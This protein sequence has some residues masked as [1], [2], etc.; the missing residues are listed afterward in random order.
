MALKQNAADQA[1]DRIRKGILGGEFPAG[2]TLPGER[3]LSERLGVSRLTLRSALANLQAQGLIEK[4]HGSGNLV[5]DYRERGGVELIAHLARHAIEGGKVPLSLLGDLLE[6]RRL[7]ATELLGLVAARATSEELRGLRTHRATMG[8]LLGDADAFM[9]ADLQF[10]RLLVRAAH[11]LTLELL[12]NTVQ[13]MVM[14]HPGLEAAFGVNAP[15]TLKTYDRVLEL[16]ES[17]DPDQVRAFARS[18]FEPLDRRTMDRL[19]EVARALEGAG[20]LKKT[21]G[22]PEAKTPSAPAEPKSSRSVRAKELEE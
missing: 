14:D 6:F 22:T 12:Y 1:A 9:R 21:A 13:R 4:V 11:N 19:E 8:P 17:R 16:L 7:I 18:A 3:D 2:T 10:A 15:A 5:L 20:Q